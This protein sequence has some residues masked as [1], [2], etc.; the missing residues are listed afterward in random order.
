MFYLFNYEIKL[1]ERFYYN[2]LIFALKP[3]D[4]FLFFVQKTKTFVQILLETKQEPFCFFSRKVPVSM[5]IFIQLFYKCL[6]C[7]DLVCQ[8]NGPPK[9]ICVS[10]HGFG[11]VVEQRL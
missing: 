2:S 9:Q 1:T 6:A 4:V 5:G 7:R 8:K 11:V 10:L 3:L